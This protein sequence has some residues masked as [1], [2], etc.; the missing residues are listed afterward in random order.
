MAV[1][2]DLV[3][4]V[5]ISS[6]SH[7]QFVYFNTNKINIKISCMPLDLTTIHSRI[8]CACTKVTPSLIFLEKIYNFKVTISNICLIFNIYIFA[9]FLLNV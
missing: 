9:V 6:A 3:L 1:C 7:T 5:A 4:F 2:V 8:V